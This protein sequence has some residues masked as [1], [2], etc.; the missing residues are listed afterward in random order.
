MF[1]YYFYLSSLFIWFYIYIY[2]YEGM[3]NIVIIVILSCIMNLCL[4]SF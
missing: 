4:L 3:Y 1:M 2:I